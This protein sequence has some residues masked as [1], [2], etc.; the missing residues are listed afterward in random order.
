MLL[1]QWYLY[2]LM[3]LSYQWNHDNV[4]LNI[5][6]EL[7]LELINYNWIQ[8]GKYFVK[9]PTAFNQSKSTTRDPSSGS[10]QFKVFWQG[11]KGG[12]NVFLIWVWDF[13][14]L[15]GRDKGGGREERG[16]IELKSVLL[17]RISSAGLCY[18]I[19]CETCILGLFDK[20]LMHRSSELTV[21]NIW[22]REIGTPT[23]IW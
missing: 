6:T 15:L 3:L 22:Q 13:F 20:L 17:S 1:Y 11:R 7:G 14:Q 23:E 19:R 16:R 2:N 9:L 10:N 8:R 12:E 5:K 4:L 18:I 21:S